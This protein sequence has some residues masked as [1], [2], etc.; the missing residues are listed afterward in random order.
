MDRVPADLGSDG[1]PLADAIDDPA[2]LQSSGSGAGENPAVPLA[3]PLA[4]ARMESELIERSR[5]RLLIPEGLQ[6]LAEFDVLYDRDDRTLWTFLHPTGRPSFTPAVLGE[7]DTLMDLVAGHFGPDRLPLD[8][9]VLGSRAPGVFCFGGDLEL[10]ANL[11]QQRDRERLR[12]YAYRSVRI[13]H[14]NL[15]ALDLPM[16]TIG[17]VQG[18]AMGGGFEALLS[19][20]V[21]IAERGATFGLPEIMFGLFPGMGAH[22]LLA[23]KLG[24][25]MAERM[26]LSNRTY[27]AE[28]LHALGLVTQVVEPGEGVDAVRRFIAESRRRLPGM[29][30]SMRASRVVA[31]VSFADLCKVGDLWA[32]TALQLSDGDIKLMRRLAAAQSRLYARVA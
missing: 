31:P 26:I 11:I 18:Q 23:R 16:L 3:V 14:R 10:F 1:Y 24:V 7:I 32:D 15:H 13:L 17:L 21:I 22:M 12:E 6:Q 25:A 20:D 9:L 8:Y 5:E 2:G 27:S 19:F 30:G 4:D 28:E 29:I